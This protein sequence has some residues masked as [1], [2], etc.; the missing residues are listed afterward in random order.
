MGK[1]WK[2]GEYVGERTLAF[3]FLTPMTKDPDDPVE[4]AGTL[5]TY[6]WTGTEWVLVNEEEEGD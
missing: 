6:E 5:H 1:E 2:P 3:N 4:L